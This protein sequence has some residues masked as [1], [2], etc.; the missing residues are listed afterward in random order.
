MI[1][2]N[3]LASELHYLKKDMARIQARIKVVEQEYTEAMAETYDLT[4]EGYKRVCALHK[5]EGD[6]S[7]E[8][9]SFL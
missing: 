9:S 4:V 2:H 6:L 5:E 8:T 7:N 3:E 1:D